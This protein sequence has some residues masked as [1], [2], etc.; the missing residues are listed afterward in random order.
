M[1]HNALGIP[2]V[3]VFFDGVALFFSNDQD[4]G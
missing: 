3:A 2:E 1:G 4:N